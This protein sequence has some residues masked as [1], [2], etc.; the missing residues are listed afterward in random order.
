MLPRIRKFWPEEQRLRD[1]PF[2][3]LASHVSFHSP[4]LLAVEAPLPLINTLPRQNVLL[5]PRFVEHS[6]DVTGEW[7]DVRRRIHPSTRSGKFR[8]VRKYGYWFDVSHE[9]AD[10]Q[11]FYDRMYL[12][13]MDNRHGDEAPLLDISKAYSLFR[14]GFLSRVLQGTDWVAAGLCE[15]RKGAVRFCELGVLDADE[16]LIGKGVMGAIY[17]GA[18]RAA[19]E[20]P[21]RRLNMTTSSP[22]LTDGLFQHKRRW[23]TDLSL[24]VNEPHRTWV[25]VERYTPAIHQFL[26]E[27]PVITVDR[28]GKLHGILSLESLDDWTAA[29]AHRWDKHFSV[30][31]LS[32]IRI[33]PLDHLR[34]TGQVSVATVRKGPE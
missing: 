8:L 27:N 1:T 10:F 30:P 13:T 23:G 19:H 21:C 2:W 25:R 33:L 20:L 7:Q 17:V 31:G 29:E 32:S 11:H 34:K 22:F 12:P 16:E 3:R 24:P 28:R 18:I 9:P 26:V 4:D 14:N 6:L 15:Q 5:L